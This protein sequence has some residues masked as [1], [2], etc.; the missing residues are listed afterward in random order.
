MRKA[1]IAAAGAGTPID[2]AQ[3]LLGSDL[4]VEFALDA[5]TGFTSLKDLSL[6]VTG[7]NLELTADGSVDLEEFSRAS[8]GSSDHHR[9]RRLEW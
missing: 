7:S 8:H 6:A 5:D 3:G 2:A 9:C 4:N 1:V